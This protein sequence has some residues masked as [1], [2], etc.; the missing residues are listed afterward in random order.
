MRCIFCKSSTSSSR[1]VEHII[2]ESL[3][4]KRHVL[5]RGIVCD[6]CNNYF[7][8]KVEK[9]FLD[10]PAVRQLRFHEDLVSKRGTL[11]QI[12]GVIA[13]DI[14]ALLTRFPKY[15]FTSVQVPEHALPKIMHARQGILIFP[16]AGNLPDAPV[17]SRFL[18][19]IALEAMALRLVE[20]SEGVA[21]LC[22]ENQL[23][24][25][26]DHARNGRISSWPVHVRTIYSP[27][28]ITYGING[29]PEQIVHE[30]DF[31]VTDRSEW[32]FIVAILGVEFT[33]NLGGPE[34]AGYLQWL[35]Q[36]KGTSP[37]YTEN[38]GGVAAMPR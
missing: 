34:I 31:L 21:Y 27:D 16:V 33:I 5:P 18:A 23:N 6:T 19:K 30:F 11:P 9:P 20:Y 26:R 29:E 7:S 32:F 15:N 12:Q 22:D 38:H 36:N 3:G 37:L 25:L 35:E 14:P 1:S 4:N 8:R 10:L 17:V 13:P 28:A 24:D 2:P